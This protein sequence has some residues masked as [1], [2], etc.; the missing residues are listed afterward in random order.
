MSCS[1]AVTAAPA[2]YLRPYTAHLPT[3]DIEPLLQAVG[4][5]IG[6][7]RKGGGVDTDLAA[8][9]FVQAFRD[10]KMGLWALD[11]MGLLLRGDE[12]I[13]Q[14]RSDQPGGAPSS[15][16]PLAAGTDKVYLPP[17]EVDQSM[18]LIQTNSKHPSL[19]V[20]DDSPTSQQVSTFVA[21]Y[22][23]VQREAA[24]Q[25]S[26]SKNQIKK[27]ARLEAAEE[28]KRKWQVK[29]PHLSRKTRGIGNTRKAGGRI[30]MI[31]GNREYMRR[32]KKRVIARKV[33]RR[34]RKMK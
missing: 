1:L 24:T 6:A 23:A 18:A 34:R 4:T 19:A 14:I 16:S 3:N 10:G 20:A 26:T 15:V 32:Q 33:T 8:R 12:N 29:H 31:G 21:S 7:I 27:R 17:S 22:F 30:F 28:R 11:D 25:L 5:R 13:S 2:S 9:A